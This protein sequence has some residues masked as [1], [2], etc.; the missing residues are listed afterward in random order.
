[1]E[2]EEKEGRNYCEIL[3]IIILGWS[4]SVMTL[5][6]MVK[7]LDRFSTRHLLGIFSASTGSLGFQIKMARKKSL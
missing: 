7:R 2:E 6:Y 1:M 4:L 5:G 3:R